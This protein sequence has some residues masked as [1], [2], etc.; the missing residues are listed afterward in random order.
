[1]SP[2]QDATKPTRTIARTAGLTSGV[3]LAL[4]GCGFVIL[5]IAPE[6]QYLGR[7]GVILAGFIP[8]GIAAWL[9]AAAAFVLAGRRVT[10]ALAVASLAAVVLQVSWIVPYWPHSAPAA[11]GDRL[12]LLTLNTEFGKV[13]PAPLAAVIQAEAPDVVVLNEVQQP[14][15]DELT[16]LGVL[17]PYT[18][19]V[20]EAPAGYVSTGVESGEGTV[21]LSRTPLLDAQQLD[22][23][24]KQYRVTVRL[25]D[26]SVTLIAGHPRNPLLGVDQWRADLS[27]LTTVARAHAGDDLVVAGDLNAVV[28]HAPL[29]ELMSTGLTDAAASSGSGWLPTYPADLGIPP[30]IAI[31]H[32]L[33]GGRV[34]ATGLRTVTLP[35][36][37]HRGLIAHLVIP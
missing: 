19:R 35:G 21:V 15:L 27:A 11:A 5:R 12:R 8:L 37:D 34:S 2:H 31:D 1:M 3:L 33:V 13:S 25:D 14:L 16:A 4:A 26:A 32:V 22:G 18:H 24:N 10:T 17:A 9:G 28:E 20:G 6:T 29:V 30:V 36:T 23:A 7:W